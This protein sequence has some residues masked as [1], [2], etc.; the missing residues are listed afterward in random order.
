MTIIKNPGEFLKRIYLLFP[1]RTPAKERDII[2]NGF[3]YET[4][5]NQILKRRMTASFAELMVIF[6]SDQRTMHI[7]RFFP[8]KSLIKTSVL[9]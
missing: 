7:N 8:A 2:D 4:C 6:V 3:F 9:W 5:L 1:F